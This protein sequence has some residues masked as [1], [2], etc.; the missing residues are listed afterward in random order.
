MLKTFDQQEN[1][2]ERVAWCVIICAP[3]LSPVSFECALAIWPSLRWNLF[4]LY[5]IFKKSLF[6]CLG[7]KAISVYC[8][9]MLQVTPTKEKV[10]AVKEEFYEN[11]IYFKTFSSVREFSI[12]L[13][14]PQ[15]NSVQECIPVGCVPPAH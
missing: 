14:A 2:F 5:S 7:N 3:L 8:V 6:L 13:C 4:F 1:G 9:S 10:F 11:N 12:R 15:H